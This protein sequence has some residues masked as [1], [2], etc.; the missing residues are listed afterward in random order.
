MMLILLPMCLAAQEKA[1]SS[2]R[3][4]V[5]GGWA[6]VLDTYLSPYSYKGGTLGL[7][8]ERQ[9]E[10]TMH[11]TSLHGSFIEN[12]AGNVN[13]YD[14]GV[15][16]GLAH[17]F[18]LLKRGAF[19]VKAGPMGHIYA[20]CLYNERNGNNPAQGRLSFDLSASA[21]GAWSFHLRRRLLIARYQ[22]D[23]PLLGCMFSP[24]YG[25]SYYE[26]SKGDR[27]HNVC[28]AWP[29]NAPSLRQMLSLDIPFRRFGLRL[30][31]LSDV[32]QS[33]V[34]HIKVHDISRSFM[35]GFVRRM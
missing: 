3:L 27:D 9:Y 4:L 10:H 33:R 20:G 29:G 17:H 24:Q 35:L 5:G 31:Y 32:R 13:E 18:Q 12:P 28:F 23:M 16:Y 19:S 15:A 22:A 6:D 21:G 25:Q 7:T 14:F 26:L 34:N 30:S 8:I 1:E 11:R 2:A